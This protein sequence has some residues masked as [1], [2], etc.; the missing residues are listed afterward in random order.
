MKIALISGWYNFDIH[1]GIE[2]KHK[3]IFE[4]L[5]TSAEK[6]FLNN[7]DVELIFISNNK[8]ITI[9][10][11]TN[12]HFEYEVGD[13]WEMCLMK[14]LSLR[15]IEKKYDYIFV[16]DNDSIIVNNIKD[17]DLLT[18][19]FYLLN[20]YSYPKIKDLLPGFTN[21]CEINLENKD[22]T[23]TMGNFFGGKQSNIIDLLKYTEKHHEIY[24]RT[25]YPKD[26]TFYVRYPEEYYLLKYVNEC[27]I[28]ATRLTVDVVPNINNNHFLSDFQD[29]INLYP[30]NIY[31]K[32]LHNTKKD[33]NTL[34]TIKKYYR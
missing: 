27:N 34:N 6:F 20:H 13:F 25:I 26:M 8:E 2:E 3:I 32:I 23:W 19:D 30:N 7:H 17:N 22:D 31:S 33:I 5:Y 4:T 12:I 18:S 11:V 9:N 14:I 24:K 16:I 29:D 10:G 28:K 1:K 21:I 15:Y